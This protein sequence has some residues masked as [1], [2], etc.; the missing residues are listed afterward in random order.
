MCYEAELKFD[1]RSTFLQSPRGTSPPGA[2]TSGDGESRDPPLQ[3]I[4]IS[5]SLETSLPIP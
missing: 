3:L 2:E 4:A 5:S 1:P